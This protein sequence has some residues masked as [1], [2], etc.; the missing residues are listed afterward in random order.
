MK[1]VAIICAALLVVGMVASASAAE[2]VSKSTLASMGFA[3]AQTMSDADGMAVR[4]KGWKG[5]SASVGGT[6]SAA[7]FDINYGVATDS[8]HYD[9]ASKHKYDSSY[10]K[11]RSDSSAGIVITMS[12]DTGYYTHS[13]MIVSGGSAKAYAK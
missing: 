6:S 11:G 12:G 1:N 5:T 8:N 2:G 13:T 9:A 4:G 3:S 7:F 10:A